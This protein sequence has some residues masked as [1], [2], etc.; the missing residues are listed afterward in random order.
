MLPS[1]Y[2]L[3]TP[4]LSAFAMSQLPPQRTTATRRQPPYRSR[5]ALE[6]TACARGAS[7]VRR[8]RQEATGAP[9]LCAQGRGPTPLCSLLSKVHSQ[10]KTCASG[11]LNVQASDGCRA[12]CGNRP[13][14]LPECLYALRITRVSTNCEQFKCR[15]RALPLRTRALLPTANL[16]CCSRIRVRPHSWGTPSLGSVSMIAATP[17]P[18]EG[19]IASFIRSHTSLGGQ[20]RRVQHADFGVRIGCN[21]LGKE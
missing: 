12:S 16:N 11:L 18:A 13:L 1:N 17:T 3:D 10:N 5:K 6:S 21:I 8:S 14:G 15:T 2:S 4:R 9:I 20:Q 19:S 7:R